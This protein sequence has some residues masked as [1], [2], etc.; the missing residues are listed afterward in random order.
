MIGHQS[1][2]VKSD[3]QLPDSFAQTF[4]K[5]EP[6]A[7]ILEKEIRLSPPIARH[8][9]RDMIDRPRKFNSQR[10]CHESTLLNHRKT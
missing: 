3:L 1:H 10:S 4:Q 5:T 7:I 2:Q 9:G 6:V 8:S